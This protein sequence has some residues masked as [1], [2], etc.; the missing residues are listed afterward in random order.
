MAFAVFSKLLQRVSRRRIAELSRK[1]G[2]DPTWPADLEL[3]KV[4]SV[5]S[6]DC[7]EQLRRLRPA[8]VLV[9]LTRVIHRE[10]LAAIDAPFINYHTGIAPQYRGI[11]GGYWAKV[12]GDLANFGVTVHL[13]DSGIDTGEVLFQARIAPTPDDN[14][15]TFPY[16]Q[17]A[18]G[19]PLL[20]QA[21][22]EALSGSLNPK[23]LQLP[24]RLWSQPTLWGYLWAGLR[25]GAW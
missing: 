1:F 11:H 20:D 12:Q 21:A 19:L 23:R 5:N 3:I 16:L 4:P 9:V 13:V 14:I 17:I 24:S 7:I 2:L 18:A 15:A 22:R 10:V 6:P 8:V 25:R